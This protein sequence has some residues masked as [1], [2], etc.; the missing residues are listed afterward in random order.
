MNPSKTNQ[1]EAKHSGGRPTVISDIVLAKLIAAFQNGMTDRIACEYAGIH[2]ATYYR[3]CKEDTKFCEQIKLAKNFQILLAGNKVTDILQHGKDRDSGP[4]ARWLL[5]KKLPEEYGTQV[6]I[7][8]NNQQNNYFNMSY[9]Q[10]DALINEAGIDMSDPSKLLKELEAV[11]K[12]QAE[13][14]SDN[15]LG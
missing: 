11:K 10:L 14:G 5:E 6:N 4:M 13:N 15:I 2:P 8:Q 3:K 1:S 12:E 7:Q 9:E